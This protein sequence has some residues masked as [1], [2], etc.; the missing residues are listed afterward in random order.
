MLNRT[1][2]SNQHLKD[3]QT[4]VEPGLHSSNQRQSLPQMTGRLDK[5]LSF[6]RQPVLIALDHIAAEKPSCSCGG[7]ATGR[8]AGPGIRGPGSARPPRHAAAA[9]ALSL[10]S[11]R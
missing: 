4:F 3:A 6:G 8:G 7:R 1:H 10:C 5:D 11:S 2:I 9:A